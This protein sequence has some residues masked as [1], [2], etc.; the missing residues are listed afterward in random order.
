MPSRSAV[1]LFAD[2][3]SSDPQRP[4]RPTSTHCQK[5]LERWLSGVL[6]TFTLKFV[7]S[8]E[9][10]QASGYVWYALAALPPEFQRLRRS[11]KLKGC[12]SAGSSSELWVWETVVVWGL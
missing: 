11:K 10:L 1:R 6:L 12:V 5:D 4:F 3:V 7:A 2:V 8:H 9:F